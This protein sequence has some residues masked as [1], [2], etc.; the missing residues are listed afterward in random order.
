M[1]SNA[2][3]RIPD[4]LGA[5]RDLLSTLPA[6]H[7]LHVGA[8]VRAQLERAGAV[9]SAPAPVAAPAPIPVTDLVGTTIVQSDEARRVCQAINELGEALEALRAVDPGTWVRL[10]RLAAEFVV[11]RGVDVRRGE[12]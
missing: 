2:I 9:E 5:L 1:T 6:Q 10:D 4:V 3:D 7:L 11:S 8:L 12:A